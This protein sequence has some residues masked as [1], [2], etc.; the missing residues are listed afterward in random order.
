M[1]DYTRTHTRDV[2]VHDLIN[3]QFAIKDDRVYVLK[4][5]PRASR[6]V[7][8]V[9]KA[10]G[11]PLARIAALVMAGRAL[12]RFKLPDDMT[13][14]PERFYIQSPLF[15][16]QKISRHYPILRPQMTS[17]VEGMGGRRQ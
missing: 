3:I 10:T 7:P 15:P 17:H 5:N 2:H 8:F 4:V 11:V 14:R 6:T 16:F 12:V 1:H 13:V 9:S